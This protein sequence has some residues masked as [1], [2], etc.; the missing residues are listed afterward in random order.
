MAPPELGGH[1]GRNEFGALDVRSVWRQPVQEY[2]LRSTRAQQTFLLRNSLVSFLQFGNVGYHFPGRR[3]L[4]EFLKPRGVAVAR[5]LEV[6]ADPDALV[7]R[8]A[9]LLHKPVRRRTQHCVVDEMGPW[10]VS[11]TNVCGT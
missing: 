5:V 9:E 1:V 11:E 8:Q 4:A 3:V 7:E 2:L 10:V 6:V